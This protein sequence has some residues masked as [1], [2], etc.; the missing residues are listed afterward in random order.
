MVFIYTAVTGAAREGARY[1]A[2]AGEGD[3]L[4]QEL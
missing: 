1:G 3:S 2:A 4:L